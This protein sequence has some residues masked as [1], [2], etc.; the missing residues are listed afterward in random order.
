MIVNVVD[1]QMNIDDA[2]SQPRIHHQWLPNTIYYDNF[3]ISPD[4]LN[5]LKSMG[6]VGFSKSWGRGIGD[7]NSIMIKGGI[8][9][10]TKDPRNEG[11][12]FGY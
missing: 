11:G 10:G 3:A 5:N 12:V 2:V 9:S 4:T 6:H 1:H 8:I 7:A